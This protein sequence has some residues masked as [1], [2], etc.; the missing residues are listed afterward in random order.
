MKSKQSVRA[1]FI[2]DRIN[3]YRMFSSLIAEGLRRGHPIECWHLCDNKLKSGD[4]GYLYPSLDKARFKEKDHIN[5]T[6]NAF[7]SKEAMA[8]A[9]AD[10]NDI[11]YVVSMNP[12]ETIATNEQLNRFTSTWCIIMYGQDT[13]RNL[14]IFKDGHEGNGAKTIFFAYTEHLFE[15]GMR[16]VSQYLDQAQSYVEKAGTSIRMIGNSMLDPCVESIDKDA[17]RKKYGIPSGKNIAIYLPYGYLPAKNFKKSRAWQAAFSSF[18]IDRIA[19]KEFDANGFITETQFKRFFR[20]LS[21]TG[22]AL[23]DPI[24][25][26]WFLNDW[27]EPAVIRNA[28]RFCD[29]NNLFLVVKPRRKFDF[30]EAVYNTADLIVDDSDSQHYPSMMQELLSVASIGISYLSWSVLEFVYQGVP[31]INIECLDDRIENPGKKYWHST[32]EGFIYACAGNVWNYSAPDFISNFA[33]L[34][35][36]DFVIDKEQRAGYFNRFLGDPNRS[37]A[38]LFFDSIENTTD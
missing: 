7:N 8:E 14:A 11:S 4:K 13:F 18:H 25:R 30:S 10:R 21:L 24:A 19:E 37:A 26:Q 17:V 12:A 31:V 22:K 9:I 35:L 2:I 36:K 1:V 6:L 15:F 32:S 28:R 20:K 29:N 33:S 23:R 5:L 34:S 16:F 27:N 3:N 38:E